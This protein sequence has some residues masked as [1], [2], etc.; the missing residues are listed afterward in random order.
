MHNKKLMFIS[1]SSV[2]SLVAVVLPGMARAQSPTPGQK[3]TTSMTTIT[4]YQSVELHPTSS[5]VGGGCSFGSCQTGGSGTEVDG[6][7][8]LRY[9]TTVSRAGDAP[10]I[11]DIQGGLGVLGTTTVTVH[12][13]GGTLTPLI[14][15]LQTTQMQGHPNA[16]QFAVHYTVSAF[17]PTIARDTVSLPF[18]S[19]QMTQGVV[20]WQPPVGQAATLT[21]SISNP[22]VGTATGSL[23]TIAA[24]TPL[25]SGTILH[26]TPELNPVLTPGLSLYD[27]K[28]TS[29]GQAE[30]QAQ[31]Y[32]ITGTVTIS[33]SS[34]ANIAPTG[35]LPLTLNGTETTWTH[36]DPGQSVT[37]NATIADT[38]G[39]PMNNTG[40]YA[41]AWKGNVNPVLA[42]ALNVQTVEPMPT[43]TQCPAP[44]TITK[45]V[46][47]TVDVPVVRTV[48]K[49][50]PVVHTVAK[51]VTQTIKVPVV[52][53]KTVTKTVKVP[54]VHIRF[55]TRI[56]WAWII[57]IDSVL[58]AFGGWWTR[59]RIL[60]AQAEGRIVPTE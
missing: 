23:I 57:A 21:M 56:P 60:A 15:I 47:K 12:V 6:E 49:D 50:V 51:T 24:S 19:D 7:A 35:T 53:V 18:A 27:T 10:I 34:G 22:S 20:E 2:L 9:T 32:G 43:P 40:F 37:E 13:S 33:G 31:R 54:V 42:A 11:L 55:Q 30:T 29:F 36:P 14:G 39:T 58:A 52:H 1:L 5:T 25:A 38:S 17:Q 26:A 45:V 46:T 16:T 3:T 48:V 44:K 8:N 59:R 28:A 41:F 4:R